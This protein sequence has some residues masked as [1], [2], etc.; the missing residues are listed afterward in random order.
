MWTKETTPTFIAVHTDVR[1]GRTVYCNSNVSLVGEE[2]ERAEREAD[3]IVQA[4]NSY[5]GMR[6][7]LEQIAEFIKDGEQ[8]DGETHEMSIDDAYQ[9]ACDAIDIAR[10]ALGR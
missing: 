6:A 9:T 1:D 8:V 10:A 7:A 2:R 3:I 5:G 4:V